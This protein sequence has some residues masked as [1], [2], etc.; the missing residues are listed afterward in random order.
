MESFVEL[1]RNKLVDK[2]VRLVHRSAC[3][4]SACCINSDSGRVDQIY[5]GTHT[6]EEVGDGTRAALR[7]RGSPAWDIRLGGSD[8]HTPEILHGFLNVSTYRFIISQCSAVSL[9]HDVLF[10]RWR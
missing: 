10:L 6:R 2:I 4:R 5:P 9:V 8:P 1:R 3:C 7:S